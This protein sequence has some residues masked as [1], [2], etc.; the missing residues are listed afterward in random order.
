MRHFGLDLEKFVLYIVMNA[1]DAELN[2]SKDQFKSA[3]DIMCWFHV[4]FNVGRN[5]IKKGVSELLVPM[6]K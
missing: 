3:I 5:I 1:C 6:A 4:E 2:A